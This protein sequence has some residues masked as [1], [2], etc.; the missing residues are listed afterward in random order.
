MKTNQRDKGCVSANRSNEATQKRT[1]PCPI[2]KSSTR[3][4]S[5]PSSKI[6]WDGTPTAGLKAVGGI[7]SM[8]LGKHEAAL[9]VCMSGWGST[10]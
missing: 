7:Y 5:P 3:D 2:S 1:T 10:G 6:W 4:L 8:I 9:C